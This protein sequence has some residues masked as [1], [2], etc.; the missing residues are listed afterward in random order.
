MARPPD[1]GKAAADPVDDAGRPLRRPT[2]RAPRT[3]VGGRAQSQPTYDLRHLREI[4]RRIFGDAYDWAGQIRTVAI[5]KSA[6]FCLPQY[7][8]SSAA[9]IFNE[10]RDEGLSTIYCRF[11]ILLGRNILR[12][13]SQSEMQAITIQ[14]ALCPI[15]ARVNPP[16]LSDAQLTGPA[17]AHPTMT[18]GANLARRCLHYVEEVS[19]DRGRQDGRLPSHDCRRS[20]SASVAGRRRQDALEAC[21]GVPGG[22]SVGASCCSTVFAEGR[23]AARWR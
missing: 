3:P 15:V 9:V 19:T 20:C 2:P 22:V 21:M 16:G 12:V 7:I 11:V 10:L 17:D 23:A 18:L 13:H 4:H 14:V 1:P 6:T 5:A 8:E